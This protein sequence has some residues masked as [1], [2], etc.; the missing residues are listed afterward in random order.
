MKKIQNDPLLTEQGFAY[1]LADDHFRL[2]HGALKHLG[3]RP[4]D[5]HYQDMFQEGCLQFVTAYVGFRR[6]HP[7]EWRQLDGPA[8]CL[9]FI[10]S[11][12]FWRLMDQLRR[13]TYIYQQ[14]MDQDHAC[15]NGPILEA[16][17]DQCSSKVDRQIESVDLWRRIYQSGTSGEQRYL[18]GLLKLRLNGKEMAAYYHVTPQTVSGWRRQV[19]RHGQRLVN[20]H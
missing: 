16:L 13:G 4:T 20:Q 1:L 14:M 11:R 19:I 12:I 5:P 8:K 10:Y 18:E 15:G 2:V 3:Q 7:T 9:K 6:L 17:V